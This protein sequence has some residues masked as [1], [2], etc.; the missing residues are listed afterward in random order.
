M[1]VFMSHLPAMQLLTSHS[2]ALDFHR[3]QGECHGS[4]EWLS[5]LLTLHGGQSGLLMRIGCPATETPPII[6]TGRD[7]GKLPGI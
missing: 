4:D 6:V 3:S 5:K 7:C 1:A 2:H